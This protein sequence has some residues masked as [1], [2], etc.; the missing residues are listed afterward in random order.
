MNVNHSCDDGR[1]K[2]PDGRGGKQ[3]C[4][5]SSKKRNKNKKLKLK[6]KIIHIGTWNV[7]TMLEAGKLAFLIDELDALN[8]N[9]SG[10]CETRW[11]KDGKFT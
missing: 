1:E 10:L 5:G 4:R 2:L 7:N 9:K 3:A 11:K 8:M 6:K